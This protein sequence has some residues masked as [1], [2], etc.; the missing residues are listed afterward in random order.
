MQIFENE[1]SLTSETFQ[2]H[3]G[4]LLLVHVCTGNIRECLGTHWYVHMKKT[5]TYSSSVS[6]S[7]LLSE[8]E[9][10]VPVDL[11]E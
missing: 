7:M 5:F 1:N 11:K 2:K 8:S 6:H 9:I 10:F 4:I 3:E